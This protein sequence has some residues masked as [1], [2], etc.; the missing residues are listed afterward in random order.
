[1]KASHPGNSAVLLMEPL[2]IPFLCQTAESSQDPLQ[3]HA[4]GVG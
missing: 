1:M 4:G 2:L 3:M